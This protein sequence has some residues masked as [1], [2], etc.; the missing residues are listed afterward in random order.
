[1][2]KYIKKT[3]K[4]HNRSKKPKRGIKKWRNKERYKNIKKGIGKGPR[5]GI[6]KK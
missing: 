2:Q 3:E 5:K 1:M 6:G 4:R